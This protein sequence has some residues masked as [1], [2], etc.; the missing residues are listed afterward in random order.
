[1]LTQLL[2]Q[3]E[4]IDSR[5][6]DI[7]SLLS[8]DEKAKISGMELLSAYVLMMRERLPNMILVDVI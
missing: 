4:S 1:M 2:L 7:E 8:N 6:L 3:V 5:D